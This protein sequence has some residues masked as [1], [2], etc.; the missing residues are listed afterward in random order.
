MDIV[1]LTISTTQKR[2]YPGMI[3]IIVLFSI[4]PNE[5]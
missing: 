2:Y 1:Y 5:W 4:A 3:K